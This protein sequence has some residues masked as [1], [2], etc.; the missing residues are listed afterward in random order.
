MSGSIGGATY[1]HNRGGAYIR[2]RS[3]PVNPNTAKQ[4]TIRTQMATVSGEWAGLTDNQRTLWTDWAEVNPIIDT[5]GQS[6]ILSGQSAFVMLNTRLVNSAQASLQVPPVGTGPDQLG[7][8]TVTA[9][10]PGTVSIAYTG[11]VLGAGEKMMVWQTLPATAGRNP[12]L[13]QARVAFYSILADPTPATGTTPYVGQVAD[14][15]NWFCA[16]LD[17]AGRI[18]VPQKHRIAFA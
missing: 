1:S 11:T 13:N 6:I 14:V 2:K 5:L 10:A 4:Q 18:S 16:R 7:T 3:V 17:A 12:N 8:V 15:S 9:T